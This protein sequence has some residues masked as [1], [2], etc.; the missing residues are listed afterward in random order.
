MKTTKS[1]YAQQ[2]RI[3]KLLYENTRNQIRIAHPETDGNF[4][5]CGNWGNVDA[6]V[7]LSRM[8]DREIKLFHLFA[9][10]FAIAFKFE[11]PNHLSSLK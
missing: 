8:Y 2:T 5:L 1:V 9:K 11:Y 7:Y 4:M 10:Y 6:R 3:S